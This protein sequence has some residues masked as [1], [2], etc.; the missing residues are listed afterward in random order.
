MNLKYTMSIVPSCPLELARKDENNVK[1]PFS[2][3]I[4][5]KSS[6]LCLK[7]LFI[8]IF[9]MRICRLIVVDAVDNKL[10][11][12]LFKQVLLSRKLC[13]SKQRLIIISR[14]FDDG[15][16]KQQVIICPVATAKTGWIGEN[17]VYFL[18]YW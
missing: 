3:C 16:D 18:T 7:C 11:I 6:T 5:L 4:G 1:L 12:V 2:W 8:L 9:L 10:L 17:L 14:F 13:E 15:S